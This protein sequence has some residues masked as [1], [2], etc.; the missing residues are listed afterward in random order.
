MRN[1]KK[2]H[3]ELSVD[4]YVTEAEDNVVSMTLYER[5][6]RRAKHLRIQKRRHRPLGQEL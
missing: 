1:D 6:I 4:V 5:F 2:L 3:V